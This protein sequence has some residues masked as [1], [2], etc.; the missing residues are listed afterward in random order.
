MTSY[1]EK[2]TTPKFRVGFQNVLK[3]KKT[4]QGDTKRD[5]TMV[6]EPGTDLSA[7]QAAADEAAKE[8]WGAKT[9]YKSPLLRHTATGDDGERYCDKSPDLYV[10]DDDAIFVRSTSYKSVG[11][12]DGQNNNED[13]FEG[14]DFYSGCYARATIVAKTWENKNKKGVSF[15]LNNVQ[16][17]AD[18]ERI[19]SGGERVDA[20]DD[21]EPVDSDDDLFGDAAA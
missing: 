2:I 6:F 18:G 7:L 17:L 16:K 1:S 8:E 9:K 21:F 13:I 19:A 14:E 11:V 10:D 5:L 4:D 3:G 15:Y 12:V 20:K